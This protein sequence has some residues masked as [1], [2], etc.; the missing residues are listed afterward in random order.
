MISDN[1]GENSHFT[2]ILE[3]IYILS[4]QEYIVPEMKKIFFS[5]KEMILTFVGTLAH[6]V[7]IL[8]ILLLVNITH[9]ELSSE[10]KTNICNN[11]IKEINSVILKKFIGLYNLYED[12]NKIIDQKDDAINNSCNDAIKYYKFYIKH[13]EGCNKI[14]NNFCKELK[15]F[16]ELYDNIM[17][18]FIPMKSW[19][20]SRLQRKKMDELNKLKEIKKVSLQNTQEEVNKNYE[21]SFHN[22]SYH[23]QRDL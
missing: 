11:Y 19:F 13:Y 12:F 16:K 18:K 2:Y 14:S 21:Q 15:N 23:A 17:K 3:M 20:H 7:K 4:F 6:N 1:V 8:I 22:I 9:N 5:K 10:V